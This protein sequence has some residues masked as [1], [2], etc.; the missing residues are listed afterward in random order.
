VFE[1]QTALA[2]K[3][4]LKAFRIAK[5]FQ[6]NSKKN[7]MIMVVSSLYRFFSKSWIV[8]QNSSLNDQVLGKMIG[9][10]NSY[11]VKEY[12]V[13]ARNYSPQKLEFIFSILQEYDLKSKG[14]NNRSFHE[15]TL[16]IELVAKILS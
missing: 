1:L 13:A 9:A 15:N 3:N 6:A 2:N 11:F 12:R 16:M 7:P 4:A 14:V 5:Y 8:S 10:Y